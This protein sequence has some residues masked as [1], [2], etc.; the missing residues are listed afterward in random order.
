MRLASAGVDR[1]ELAGRRDLPDE[2]AAVL[3]RDPDESVRRVLASHP[4]LPP[5]IQAI[6]AADADSRVRGQLAEGSEFFTTV[7]VHGRHFPEPLAR[8][9][10]EALARDPEPKV[11]RALGLNRGLP[12]DV[13]AAMLDD[14]DPRTAA[15]AA[16][17]WSPTPVDRIDD[18]LAC[19]RGAWGRSMLLSRLKEPLPTHAAHA[20]L[21]DI[22][23]ATSSEY[24]ASLLRRIAETADLDDELT[25]RFLASGDLRAAVAANPTLPTE[26]VVV[27][28]QDPDNAVRAAVAARRGLDPT[29]RESIPVDYDDRGSGIVD[30]LL[31]EDLTAADQ[32]GFARSRHQIFRKTLTMRTD[33]AD[34]TLEILAQDKSFA[35]R[36]FV[37][38]RQ[39][40][41]PGWLLAEIAADWKSYSRWDMLAH[42]NFPADAANHL[43]CSDEPH[44]R[45]VSAA[46]PGL[47]AETIEALLADD[48]ANVRRRAA[49]NAA[50]PQRRLIELL[51]ADDPAVAAG[52]AENRS[53]PEPVMRQILDRAGL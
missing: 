46:H 53:L 18:L 36:L 3:V 6:L 44:D 19:A 11:R 28:A 27:L 7:G 51:G 21:A 13:R 45:L 29:T 8:E 42:K 24:D 23:G 49:T 20:M 35:V 40:N 2:A 26:H 38:E 47:P 43:A 52:A 16:E 12:D 14:P 33:I 17:E 48:D 15:I 30:W 9:V 37:C 34:E 50:I 39:P 10:Y 4:N 1:S 25:E 5:E 31:T 22:D 41:A 32:L